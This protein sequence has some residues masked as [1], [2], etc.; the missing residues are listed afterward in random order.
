LQAQKLVAE[1]DVRFDFSGLED[2]VEDAHRL[3]EEYN[4][5]LISLMNQFGVRKEGEVL[6][7]YILKFYRR[8]AKAKRKFDVRQ[9][10]MLAVKELR[11]WA[12]KTFDECVEDAFRARQEDESMDT[13]RFR[14]AS[15]WYYITYHPDADNPLRL[16][17]FPWTAAGTVLAC[18]ASLPEAPDEEIVQ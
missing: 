15:A 7:G 9:Q 1:Y 2:Y 3:R 13:I 14:I 12:R 17:S 11:A 10:V 5:R 8:H 6:T 16:W 18:M 4:F